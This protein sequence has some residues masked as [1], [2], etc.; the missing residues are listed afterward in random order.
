MELTCDIFFKGEKNAGGPKIPFLSFQPTCKVKDRDSALPGLSK[1][2]P[3][4]ALKG[5]IGGKS[6]ALSKPSK[7]RLGFP[8]RNL[9]LVLIKN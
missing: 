3:R 6:F 2:L 4:S 9:L 8:P 7:P 1:H 5:H